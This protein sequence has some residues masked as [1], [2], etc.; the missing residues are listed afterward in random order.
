[1]FGFTKKKKDTEKRIVEIFKQWLLSKY[2]FQVQINRRRIFSETRHSTNIQKSLRSYTNT[3][4]Q[5]CI[6]I[7]CLYVQPEVSLYI[8]VYDSRNIE[9]IRE[10]EI[11]NI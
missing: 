1:M 6:S 4:P 5:P 8:I 9:D 11:I 7:M 2:V 3:Y 10:T